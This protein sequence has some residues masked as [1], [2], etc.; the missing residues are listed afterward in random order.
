MKHLTVLLHRNTPQESKP[1]YFVAHVLS[2]TLKGANL[3]PHPT[4]DRDRA[5]EAVDAAILR[6][7][8]LIEPPAIQYEIED[9]Q[10]VMEEEPTL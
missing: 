9:Y 8:K 5:I 2:G 3:L 1:G 10:E 7:F 6:Q 4:K